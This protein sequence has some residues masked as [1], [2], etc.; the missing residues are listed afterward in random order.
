MY[1]IGQ[2]DGLDKWEE[3]T[4]RSNSTVTALCLSTMED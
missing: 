4:K 3:V 1:I 2:K